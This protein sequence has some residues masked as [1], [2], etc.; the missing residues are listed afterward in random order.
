MAGPRPAGLTGRPAPEEH[1]PYFARYIEQVDG[2]RLLDALRPRPLAE[3]LRGADPA[4][5]ASAYAPGKWTLAA[6][7]QH[8]ID[9]ERI[10]STRALRI[11]RGDTTPLPGFEQDGFAA[12][13]PDRP[14]AALADELDAV[15][16]ATLALF[17]SVPDDALLRIG[18]ASGG[19]LSTRAAGWIIAGHERHH[20]RIVRERY[21]T[22]PES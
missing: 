10:F 20:A 18:T 3:F 17:A 22:A 6:V 15:R 13:A 14:L 7:G 2:D 4:L 12:S 11:A 9:T 1:L 19:P 8:V 21:L 16:A 5:A